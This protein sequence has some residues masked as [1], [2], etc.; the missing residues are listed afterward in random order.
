M[1][2]LTWEGLAGSTPRWHT[3]WA[4]VWRGRLY[5]HKARNDPSYQLCKTFWQACANPFPVSTKDALC[6]LLPAK[7]GSLWIR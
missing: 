3:R 4:T 5:I 2:W 6:V 7:V 1:Q